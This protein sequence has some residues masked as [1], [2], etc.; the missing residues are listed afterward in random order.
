MDRLVALHGRVL[1][2][3]SRTGYGAIMAGIA[4]FDLDR[5]VLDCNSATLWVRRQVRQGHMGKLFAAKMAGMIGL[6]Q[7]GFGNVD[8]T[9]K[10]AILALKGQ[11][12]S[13]IIART[14]AF[15]QDEIA[16]RVRPGVA[17]VLAAH[18]SQGEALVLLTGSSSYMS[19]LVVEA[20]GLDGALCTRFE[21]QDGRFTGMGELCYGDAKLVAAQAYLADKEAALID[22]AFY[23]DSFTDLP[24]MLRVGRPVAVAPDPRLKRHARRAGWE[25]ADWG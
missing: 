7:L 1:S 14:V 17:A 3:Q 16:H 23:T 8:D 24:V 22:C 4:F 11:D 18:R 21:V 2:L 9:V 25:I 5:T 13:D 10:Q 15:W 12:E 19:A 20:L 6:Y